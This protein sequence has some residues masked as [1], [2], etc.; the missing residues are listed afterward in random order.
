MKRRTALW[1]SVITSLL[2]WI[3]LMTFSVSVHAEGIWLECFYN[4][5]TKEYL[6]TADKAEYIQLLN[7]YKEGWERY[8]TICDLPETS[9]NPVY[10]LFNPASAKHLYSSDQN[11]IAVLTSAGWLNEGVAF[12]VADDNNT[13][14]VYRLFNPELNEHQFTCDLGYGH[15]ME[16]LGWKIEGIAFYSLEGINNFYTTEGR[17]AY[18][19]NHNYYQEQYQVADSTNTLPNVA[20][21]GTQVTRQNVRKLCRQLGSTRQFYA[22]LGDYYYE[23]CEVGQDN[24]FAISDY[25]SKSIKAEGPDDVEFGDTSGYTYKYKGRYNSYSDYDISFRGYKIGAKRND[26]LNAYGL[27]STSGGRDFGDYSLGFHF[28]E[29]NGEYILTGATIHFK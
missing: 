25:R 13:I 6:Y 10:R 12:Y 18:S 3:G 2:F 8:A 14:P 20:I 29:I 26:V 17:A 23:Y 16:T 5:N 7:S 24:L 28:E 15:Y 11:E 27:L 1:M 19:S 4:K 21:N 22:E 9:S